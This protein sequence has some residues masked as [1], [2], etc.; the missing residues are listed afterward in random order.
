MA[1]AIDSIALLNIS[2]VST[3][4]MHSSRMHHSYPSIRNTEA[5]TIIAAVEKKRTKKLLWPRTPAFTPERRRGICVA[6]YVREK[7]DRRSW[8]V[9][10]RIKLSCPNCRRTDFRIRPENQDGFGN[11]S[12]VSLRKL[13]CYKSLL[14]TKR[15]RRRN[16]RA[17]DVAQPTLRQEP[18]L[19]GEGHAHAVARPDRPRN[20]SGPTATRRFA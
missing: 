12:C 13:F 1:L 14:Q 19:D 17:V 11:P 2:A 15:P 4:K 16:L 3:E 9:R 6:K 18:R 10:R 7:W 20:R 5:A 8:Q